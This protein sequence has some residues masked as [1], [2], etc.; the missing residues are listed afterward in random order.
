MMVKLYTGRYD[1]EMESMVRRC[2]KCGDEWPLT[3]EFY[4]RNRTE[5]DGYESWCKACKNELR[6]ALREKETA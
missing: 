5:S 2:P 3:S 4:H 6:A 1:E